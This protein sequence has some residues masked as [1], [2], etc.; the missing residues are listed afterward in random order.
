M[1][2]YEGIARSRIT[3][4]FAGKPRA[5]ELIVVLPRQLT[6]FELVA[7]Q[8][9]NER[10]LD[11]AIGVQLDA[12]GEIVGEKRRGRGDEEYRKAIR[13]RI[14]VNISKGR[15]SDVNYVTQFLSEGD[16]VQY[17]E[18]YPATV[19]MF[20]SGFDADANLPTDVQ[21]VA[22][23]AICDIPVVVSFGDDP[24]RLSGIMGD[25]DDSELAGVQ[26]GVFV[27]MARQRLMTIN[28]KRIR[29]RQDYT[30]LPA[31]PRLNGVF[32]A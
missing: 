31:R 23:A 5:S 6:V 26:S 11:L 24:F 16:D 25:E 1:M 10:G 2:D 18:S 28:G 15:P 32:Q 8:V 22:P 17:L 27:T 20:T 9:K 21:E 7:D 30:L 19:Y 13:F 12:L 29:V 14:F 4:V 3:N